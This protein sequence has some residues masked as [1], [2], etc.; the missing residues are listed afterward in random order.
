MSNIHSITSYPP[1]RVVPCSGAHNNT[2]R[3]TAKG[4]RLTKTQLEGG[5]WWS[6]SL[7]HLYS[8]KGLRNIYD[9]LCH[10][11]AVREVSWGQKRRQF[12]PSPCLPPLCWFSPGCC[13]LSGLQEHT[14]GSCPP[15]HLLWPTRPSLQGCPQSVLFP[16]CTH[17]WDSPNPGAI[18]CTCLVEPH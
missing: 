16:V 10:I 17:T 7:S 12:S 13:W 8:S 15:S 14:A 3:C 6:N 5:L 9:N 4:W 1:M 11:S 18:L 2:L